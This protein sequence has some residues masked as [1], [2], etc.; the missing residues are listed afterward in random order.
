MM[1]LAQSNADPV[2]YCIASRLYKI[3][4]PEMQAGISGLTR[5]HGYFAFEGDAIYERH[6]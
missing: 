2:A 6:C 1:A 3:A 5:F 4:D